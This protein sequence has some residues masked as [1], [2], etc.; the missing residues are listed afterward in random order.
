MANESKKTASK[1]TVK[2]SPRKPN[3]GKGHSGFTPAGKDTRS[4][5]N[6][7]KRTG[8]GKAAKKLSDSKSKKGSS[9]K[10]KK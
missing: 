9:S 6:L 4:Q 8:L 2:S 1:K 3:P 10:G 5:S 7:E